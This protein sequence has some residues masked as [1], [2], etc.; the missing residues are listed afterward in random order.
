MGH[1]SSCLKGPGRGGHASNSQ[2]LGQSSTFVCPP[3][4]EMQEGP[5]QVGKG[6]CGTVWAL[7]HLVLKTPNEGM[8]DQLWNDCCN[9]RKIEEAFQQAPWEFRS[10]VNLPRWNSWVQPSERV[11]WTE[12]GGLL[13]EDFQ[14]TSGILSTRIHPL[15]P[16]LREVLVDLFAPHSVKANKA[17]F[18]ASPENHDCLVRLYLGRRADR[19]A[20][21]SFRLR[22]FDLMVNEMEYLQ[23]DTGIWA[24]VMAQTLAVLHWRARI[25]AN[26][27]EFVLGRT[28]GLDIA[29]ATPQSE[30]RGWKHSGFNNIFSFEVHQ[31]SMGVWLLDFDQCQTFP[32]SAAGVKQLEKA[33]YFNHPY[34]PRPV[35]KHPN[36]MAL[37][38]TFKAAYLQASACLTQTEM[39]GLFI[40]AV[41]DEGRRRAA[42]GS[43]F[44]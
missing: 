3:S 26:D 23:L 15:P 10:N 4:P 5:K 39:P 9:H 18:L 41:E 43:I 35:S 17:N 14:P 32:E 27:V 13:P 8:L 30:T 36:D 33:F 29:P 24:G 6:Q 7:K 16:P 28:P 44:Q 31:R 42:G 40:E 21:A 20:P 38:E 2:R 12:F 1:G 19:S 11:F 34:Y 22:N 25:D 37:W